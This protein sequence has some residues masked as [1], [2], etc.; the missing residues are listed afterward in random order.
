MVFW[1]LVSNFTRTPENRVHSKGNPWVISERPS[2]IPNMSYVRFFRRKI[3]NSTGGVDTA[4]KVC[5]QELR[6]RRVRGLG[7]RARGQT[8]ER[9]SFQDTARIL[10]ISDS[11]TS[12]RNC[13]ALTDAAVESSR[14]RLSF[15]ASITIC[16]A[17]TDK[18]L[19][20]KPTS[21]VTISLGP[22]LS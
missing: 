13:L 8:L 22:P 20:R 16:L 4:R 19:H 15:S 11:K 5:L 3:S 6:V 21:L 18:L 1:K 9:S 10:I 2:R 14:R 17:A 7:R 12:G